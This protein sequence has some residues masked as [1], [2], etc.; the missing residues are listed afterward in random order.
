MLAHMHPSQCRFA[1]RPRPGYRALPIAGW[2]NQTTRC[3]EPLCPHKALPP[4]AWH[5]APRQRALP[6][7]HR[8]YGLMRQTKSLPPASIQPTP[9]G[10]CRLSPVP[11]GRWPVPALSLQSLYGCLA[12]YP[13]APSRCKRPL[14]SERHRLHPREQKF[15]APNIVVMQLQRRLL[16]EAADSS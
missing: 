13:V 8:S 15:S 7:L 1:C 9:V 3:P 5:L 12:P 6:L 14:L 16:F 10:L 2:L 4:A 11:A